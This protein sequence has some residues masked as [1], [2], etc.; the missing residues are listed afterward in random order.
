MQI[1]LEKSNTM[2]TR[3]SFLAGISAAVAGWRADATAQSPR[4]ET[5]TQWMNAS[6][7]ERAAGVKAC[8]DRIRDMDPKIQAWVQVAPQ[9][10][11]GD[12]PL[13]GIPFGAKDIM[14]TRGLSTEYGS[15]IYKG[16][17]GSTDADI[18][19]SLRRRGAILLG[20]THTTAFA[21]RTP[22]PTHNPRNLEH[23]PGGSSS[24]SAAA[25]AA[26]MV[27]FALGTQTRGSILRPASYCGV[28]GFKP[29]YGLISI[30]GVLPYAKSLD[31]IGFFTH[32]PADML[33]LWEAM[34]HSSGRD[35]TLTVGVPDPM[36]EVDVE[37]TTAVQRAIDTL[38]R[39]GIATRPVDIAGLLKN[40][41]AA[42]NDVSVYEAA[43]FH[44]Q[45]WKEHGAKLLELADLVER[46]LKM[47]AE[48]YERA[49]RE[50]REGQSRLSE[51]YKTTQVILVPA[52][53][54]SAPRGLSNTGDPRMNAPWTGLGTPAIS[55]PMPVS[56]L[57]LG[58]QIT[59]DRGQD[60]RVL[61]AAVL[62][63][64][65]LT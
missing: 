16:R 27:P 28:T 34:G 51:L 57:P 48:Q 5:V 19:T 18:V 25:V 22:A 47:P 41:D 39:A 23:T 6:Q 59:A 4:L 65:L 46:G 63:H 64:R 2:V 26:G 44:E 7:A 62:L 24:G 40:V 60:A 53:T 17:L 52:A 37:M 9:P 55:I 1:P 38:R 8:L 43:R 15:A 50:I 20:K 56:G 45:R 54:G 13:G 32:T 35:E 3:R 11:L 30:D 31:T 21:Y 33:A 36:P 42:T 49:R 14:E 58:L 12:G 10:A 29:S 61:R